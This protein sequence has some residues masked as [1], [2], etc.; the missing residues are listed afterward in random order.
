MVLAFPV[1]L[2]DCGFVEP[3]GGKQG[4]PAKSYVHPF[5]WFRLYV[6]KL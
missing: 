6:P 5:W 4:L 1:G 2:G 3:A